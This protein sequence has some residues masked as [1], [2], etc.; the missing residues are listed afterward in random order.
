VHTEGQLI[1][2]SGLS[3]IVQQLNERLRSFGGWLAASNALGLAAAKPSVLSAAYWF[4]GESGLGG[5][6][7]SDAKLESRVSQ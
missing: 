3:S 2:T 1:L 7:L 6:G 5:L 4:G